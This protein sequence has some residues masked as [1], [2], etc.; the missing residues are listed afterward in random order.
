V[1]LFLRVIGITNAALWFG[2]ALALLLIVNPGFS[3]P[4]MAEI[5]PVSHS[6]AAAQILLKRFYEVQYCCGAVAFGH[7]LLESL[8]TGKPWGRWVVFLVVGVISLNL[9]SGNVTQP[10]LERLHLESYGQRSTPQQRKEANQSFRSWGN[11]LNF[12][13]FILTLGLWLHLLEVHSPGILTRFTGAGKLG[14]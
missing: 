2:S 1:S 3:S 14:G 10:K 4:A 7:L 13:N 8:Y 11:L 6:G 12:S 5:L 9:F